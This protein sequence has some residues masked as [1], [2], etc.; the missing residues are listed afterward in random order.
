MVSETPYGVSKIYGHVSGGYESLTSN[1]E[2]ITITTAIDIRPL[3]H[4]GSAKSQ[5]CLDKLIEV[6]S[7]RGQPVIMGL[8]GGSSTP[9]SLLLALE[10]PTAWA[11]TATA[12]STPSYSSTGMTT[13]VDPRANEDLKNRI[14]LDGVSFGFGANVSVSYV[15]PV[16]GGTTTETIDDSSTLA[17]AFSTTLT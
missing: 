6:V 7:L 13:A 10:H 9:F 12:S 17:V 11:S 15:D 5:A 2:F 3:A 4:S 16:A 1:F 14:K 8:V